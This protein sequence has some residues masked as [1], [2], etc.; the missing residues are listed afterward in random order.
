MVLQHSFQCTCSLPSSYSVLHSP[1]LIFIYYT[2]YGTVSNPV[3]N[4]SCSTSTNI[5]PAAA[6]DASELDVF[7]GPPV[8]K[9]E[10]PTVGT[11]ALHPMGNQR[12]VASALVDVNRRLALLVKPNPVGT[13]TTEPRQHTKPLNSPQTSG[14]NLLSVDVN[15]SNT[16]DVAHAL[17]RKGRLARSQVLP[18][19]GH[20]ADTA[21]SPAADISVAADHAIVQSAVS[22][23]I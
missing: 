2:R 21:V 13:A 23:D 11:G 5:C 15:E 3:I 17:G 9:G 1:L 14:C 20:L 7:P 6:V 18:E 10:T 19:R 16:P 22:V 4:K 8:V 12:L